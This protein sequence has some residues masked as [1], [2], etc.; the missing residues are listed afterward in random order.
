MRFV[1]VVVSLVLLSCILPEVC[2]V[3]G[4][5]Q[6]KA[7]EVSKPEIVEDGNRK[8]AGPV[9]EG[10]EPKAGSI[11]SIIYLTGYRLGEWTKTKAFFIQNGVELPARTAG[12]WF[13][14]NQNRER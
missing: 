14:S 1:L 3:R 4:Q 13:T 12:G 6:V 8:Y 2:E 5:G 9:V 7:P 10:W 11:D